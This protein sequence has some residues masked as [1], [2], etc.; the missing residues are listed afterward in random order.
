M[1]R[2][3]WLACLM[4]LLPAAETSPERCAQVMKA[5]GGEDGALLADADEPRGRLAVEDGAGGEVWVRKLK[6]GRLA[7]A[8]FNRGKRPLQVDVIWK[9]IGLRGSPRVRDLLKGEERG[10]V[11]G[12]FA[13]RIE[14]SG[15]A[16]F[17]VKP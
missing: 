9:E 17:S 3:F 12:G 5:I 16:L 10:K 14:P 7:V 1:P 8:L 6:K 4:P 13:E 15:C 2:A 11:H